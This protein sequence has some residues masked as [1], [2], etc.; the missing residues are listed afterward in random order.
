VTLDGN[1][2]HD[3]LTDPVITDPKWG[4][5]EIMNHD[6]FYSSNPNH[7]VKNNIIR[8]TK[9]GIGIH[10]G[11]TVFNNVIY[12]QTGSYRGISIDNPDADTY[13]RRIFHNTIDLPSSRAVVN[14]GA[15]A[16]I[17]N[18]IGPNTPNNL[19]TSP[20][21]FLNQAGADYRL[22]TGS[23]AINAGQALSGSVP[24]D[25]LGTQRPI[26]HAPDMGAYEYTDT[27]P[28]AAPTSITVVPR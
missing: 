24:T 14:F 9:T 16:D 20:T 21:L 27:W 28:P 13:S 10:T 7:I 4:A 17:R 22:A 5:I 6:R 1:T 23:L 12:G 19:A 8:T 15:T 11:T 2:M 25:I 3:C 18:N 26:G